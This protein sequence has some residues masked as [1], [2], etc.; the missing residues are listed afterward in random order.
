MS[1]SR[2]EIDKLISSR[3]F[4]AATGTDRKLTELEEKN[5]VMGAHA[6]AFMDYARENGLNDVII[7]DAVRTAQRENE[8]FKAG[9][10]TKGN[11][12]YNK[13][14]PHQEGRAVDWST[15]SAGNRSKMHNL[16]AKFASERGLV[17]PKDEPWHVALPKSRLNV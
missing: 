15:T 8:L 17:I 1:T 13:I 10:P 6:R 11:D 12:G 3:S 7:K 16:L 2:E 14:S 5:P 4:S 9:Y